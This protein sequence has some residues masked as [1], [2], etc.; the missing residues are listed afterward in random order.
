M[1]I[2]VDKRIPLQAKNHL[3]KYGEIYELESEGIVDGP[4]SEH[5]DIF[6]CQ[7]QE[8]IIV[9]PQVPSGLKEKLLQHGIEINFGHAQLNSSY[10]ACASYNAVVTKK[11]LVHNLQITDAGII[12][13]A[14]GLISINVRQGFTRCSVLPV[15]DGFITSD[16]GIYR[17][18]KESGCDALFVRLDDIVLPG[19]RHGF[20]GGCCGTFEDKVFINGSLRNFKDGMLV[21]KYLEFK[22]CHVVELHEGPLFD[23]GSILFLQRKTK[24][25]ENDDE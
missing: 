16:W 13:A 20:F 17:K 11:Y 19:H 23:G 10:P 14:D 18:L 9:S 12:D 2:I 21:A 22:G 25:A 4:I 7:V 24:Q 6:L 1:L 5:P 8:I 15:A 3:E